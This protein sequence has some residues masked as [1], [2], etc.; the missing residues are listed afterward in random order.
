MIRVLPLAFVAFTLTAAPLKIAIGTLPVGR[1]SSGG[2]MAG[3]DRAGTGRIIE[4]I[5]IRYDTAVKV[6]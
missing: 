6:V 5:G 1:M 4:K 3:R 2:W